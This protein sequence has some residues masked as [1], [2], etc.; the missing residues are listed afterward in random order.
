MAELSAVTA[1]ALSVLM[2]VIWNTMARQLPS[3]AWPIWWVLLGHL[4][5]LGPWGVYHLITEVRWDLNFIALLITSALANAMYFV[6]L[7]FAYDRAPV[8]LVY[9]LARSSPIVIALFSMVIMQEQLGLLSWIG[10][11]IGVLG[12]LVLTRMQQQS[13]DRL[14]IPWAILAM[15][16]TS[17]YSL[18]DKAATDFLPSFA[19]IV[20]FISVGYLASFITMTCM[21]RVTKR[22]WWPAK[23]IRISAFIIGGLCVGL[24]YALVVHAMRWLPSAEVVSYTNAGIVM[25]TLISIFIFKERSFWKARLTGA[26]TICLGLFVMSLN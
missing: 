10:I 2:H 26:L 13:S 5:L 4:V 23:G 18:S 16:G 11:V 19:S 15:L 22:R 24:A 21:H 3:E 20:G 1:I 17:I 14:A 12:L 8:A 6:S 25:A 9:P 7:K